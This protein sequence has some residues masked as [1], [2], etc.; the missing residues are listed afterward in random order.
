MA[1][2][3]N[4]INQTGAIY[5]DNSESIISIS[6]EGTKIAQDIHVV[7]PEDNTLHQDKEEE[8]KGKAKAADE[9]KQ[10]TNRQVVMLV[11]SLLNIP[12]DPKYTNQKQLALFISRL[13]GRSAGSIRKTIMDDAKSGWETKQARKDMLTVANILD[14]ISKKL[15]DK[16]RCDAED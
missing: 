14:P 15:A 2:I 11:A 6:P 5:N 4:F 16:L 3:N 9:E 8:G 7:K 10:M 13:T 1:R 12:L